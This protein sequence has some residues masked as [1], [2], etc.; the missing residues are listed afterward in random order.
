MPCVP[1][2][3]LDVDNIATPLPFNGELPSEFIPSR[4]VTV[5]VGVPVVEGLTI[6][7]NVTDCPSGDGFAEEVSCMLL[8][9]SCTVCVTD[10]VCGWKV[11]SPE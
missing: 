7:V 10:I 5:P 8:L 6:A 4:K 3:R 11:L 9:S 1:A 2:L